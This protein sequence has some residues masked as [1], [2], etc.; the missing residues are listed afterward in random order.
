MRTVEEKHSLN[1]IVGT[2]IESENVLVDPVVGSCRRLGIALHRQHDTA[3]PW[4][5]ID[6]A[7]SVGKT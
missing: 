5:D 7:K 6:F 1:W 2:T 4:L 3:K